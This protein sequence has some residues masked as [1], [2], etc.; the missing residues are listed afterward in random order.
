MSQ[1]S[2]TT[3]LPVAIVLLLPVLW[4]RGQ[5]H[6][7]G[8]C[9]GPDATRGGV[10]LPGNCNQGIALWQA[11]PLAGGGSAGGERLRYAGPLTQLWCLPQHFLETCTEDKRCK[12]QRIA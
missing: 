5:G 4:L 2:A 3:V 6:S 12:Q 11:V 8:R 10:A 9:S 1:N 7:A